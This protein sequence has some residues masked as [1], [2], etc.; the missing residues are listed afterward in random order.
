MPLHIAVLV[1]KRTAAYLEGSEA[2]TRPYLA[3]LTGIIRCPDKHMMS[4]LYDIIDILEG[5]N[6][7]TLRF[8]FSRWQRG[9]EVLENFYN[10]LAGWRGESLEDSM[11]AIVFVQN[12]SVI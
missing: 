3:E 6:S 2:H 12:E 8:A 5:N 9:E 7:A 1:F 11:S 4:D 10:S